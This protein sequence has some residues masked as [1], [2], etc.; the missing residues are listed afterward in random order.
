M[1]WLSKDDEMLRDELH[2]LPREF[3]D[4][5]R[6]SKISVDQKPLLLKPFSKL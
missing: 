3:R 6:V 5:G 2:I 4:K 1:I